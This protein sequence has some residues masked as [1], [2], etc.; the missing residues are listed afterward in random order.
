MNNKNEVIRPNYL[1]LII[2]LLFFILTLAILVYYIQFRTNVTPKASSNIIVN[3][4]SVS[5]SYVFASPVRA[6]VKGDLI[7]VTVFVLDSEGN[8]LFDK[9]VTLQSSSQN[10]SISNIQSLTDET[11]KAFFDLSSDVAGSYIITTYV[12]GSVLP[13][14]LKV[15]FDNGAVLRNPSGS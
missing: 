1:L 15:V 4:V 6:S 12:E 11:G 3:N 9:N 8:G 7:R 13:Q 5:N 2:I 14:Q 10:I